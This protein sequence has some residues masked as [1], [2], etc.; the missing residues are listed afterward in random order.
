MIACSRSADFAG[1]VQASPSRGTQSVT[2]GCASETTGGPAP[3]GWASPS[4]A[5]IAAGAIAWPELRQFASHLSPTSLAPGY[6]L[7][8]AVKALAHVE[9]GAVVRVSIPASER[10]RLSLYY[11]QGDPRKESSSGE[12]YRVADGETQVTFRAC[13]PGTIIGESGFPGYF[14]AAGAQCAR[15]NIYTG[16]SSRPLQRQIPSRA[17]RGRPV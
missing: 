6:G 13:A 16:S 5:T 17:Q 4:N 3:P 9:A 15:V 14:I 7:A 11:I 12:L 2:L 8:L 10:A 1:S